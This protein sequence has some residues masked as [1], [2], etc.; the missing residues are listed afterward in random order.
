MSFEIVSYER[1]KEK[2]SVKHLGL[3]TAKKYKD[4]TQAFQFIK[5]HL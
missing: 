3:E 5:K 2:V 4:F 1:K